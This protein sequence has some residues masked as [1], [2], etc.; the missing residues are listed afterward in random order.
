MK[1]Y[2][3]I[4]EIP[5]IENP[6]LT[7]GTYDGVHLG[8]Q[9]II[10]F[11]K[12]N[13]E[14]IGG[15]TVIF[16]FH[17]HP[18][19][20]LHPDDHGMKLIQSIDERIR[21]LE[22]F[23]IDHLILFPFTAEF[24]RLSATEFVRD[25]LVNQINVAKMTIGYNHHFGRNREGNLE[26]L[27]EL[28][29]VYDFQV[30]E[31]PAFRTGEVSISSTKI[32]KAI[33]S[34]DMQTAQQYLGEPFGFQGRVVKGDQIGTKIGFP[35][36]NILPDSPHQV[37]PANGVYAVKVTF[38]NKTW[39][40]MMNIGIRPTVSDGTEQRL[41]VHLFDFEQDIYDAYLRIEF[42]QRIRDE[43]SFESID[44]LKKQLENDQTTCLRVLS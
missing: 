15:E 37:I 11:L 23:G 10:S 43:R 8:H 1:V 22:Q 38:Q 19:M 5:T 27:K 9:E 6:V 3:S 2:R 29:V 26:I 32:R 31:I 12:K 20:V 44:A 4:N 35:T 39:G 36:A 34:G 14:A 18:R 13:A 17:P 24:S 28:G 42:I 41:E 21:K 25:I 7:L 16:T 40:G 33:A 30:E